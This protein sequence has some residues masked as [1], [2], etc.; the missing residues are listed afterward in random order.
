M[1]AIWLRARA[2]MRRRVAATLSLALLLGVGGGASMAAAAG[3]RR[4]D[5][6][7]PRFLRAY[8]GAQLDI[9][10]F[11]GPDSGTIPPELVAST[12]GAAAVEHIRW[13]PMRIEDRYV[14][15]ISRASDPMTAPVDRFKVIAGRA[16]DPN[17]ADEAVITP[18]GA[19]RG[20]RLGMTFPLATFPDEELAVFAKAVEQKPRTM[21]IVGVVAAP[22]T[23][24]PQVAET[25]FLMFLT[26]AF[27]R[28]YPNAWGGPDSV[29]VRLR[30]G[31]DL[32]SFR[33]RVEEHTDGSP[34]QIRDRKGQDANV[35][36]SIHIQAVALWIVAAL[37]ALV[38]LLLASQTIS[39]Q[40]AIDADDD[41]TLS[42]LGMTSVQTSAVAVVR[43]I[44]I[45]A[46]SIAVA[47][48]VSIVSSAWMPLGIA[49]TAEPS[50]G[51]RVD[52][53]VIGA[54]I[55]AIALG[56]ALIAL[57][58]AMKEAR[59][60]RAPAH[61]QAS[62]V[63]STFA[64]A[65]L[66]A[67][68]VIGLR[69]ALERGR[70]RTAVPVGTSIAGI[71]IGV[72]ALAATLVF[73]SSMDRLRSEPELYGV[74]W[75]MAVGLGEVGGFNEA[76]IKK[77][78]AVDG[79]SD[80]AI[81]NTGLDFLLNGRTV[82]ALALSSVRGSIDPPVF[83]GRA[84]HGESEILVGTRT[85]RRLGL[86]IGDE[87]EMKPDGS[88]A[89]LKLRIVGRGVVATGSETTELGEGAVIPTPAFL[90]IGKMIGL[91]G[92]APGNAFIRLNRGVT[93]SQMQA[94]LV[95][96]FAPGTNFGE[97]VYEQPIATPSDIASFGGVNSL[98]LA[99]ESL[100]IVL[101][102]ATLAHTLVTAIRRR[103]RDLA[104]VKTLGFVRRQ[105]RLSVAWQSSAIALVACACALPLGAVAGR[106][107]WLLFAGQFGVVPAP[108]V[109][110]RAIA[111]AVPATL[112]IANA[113]SLIP[114]AL[115]ARTRP[116]TVL[117]TE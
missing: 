25:S 97:T 20:L 94:R 79:I 42:A 59:K 17:R 9:A 48:L 66:G 44:A 88:R 78:A 83:E 100:L 82:Q 36:R 73:S 99:L 55:A 27:Y 63:A 22:G 71:A 16:A 35:Q 3:A 91:E 39:R 89:A 67:S 26:P 68:G 7:Y 65:G 93:R 31:V 33:K 115:A 13:A 70:G 86:R 45:A 51:V 57:L 75:D 72:L 40:I 4:T 24:P 58:S 32:E 41:A 46:I 113:I 23:F 30:D 98:P 49:G 19:Q 56:V 117:R 52:A 29:F 53:V 64:R 43:V 69:F 1:R 8:A 5:T 81:G 2:Q 34:S 114:G 107:L 109:P 54:G 76:N 111:L 85:M 108:T 96:A 77:I 10:N 15:A 116:A 60:R 50:P 11:P 80:L 18:F 12:E 105:T 62:T 104:I 103:R 92:F 61:N 74:T 101:S 47:S 28:E 112:L 106:W 90:K 6:A 14:Q 84:P 37:A 38:T 102:A 21:R 87:V 95:A 110:V